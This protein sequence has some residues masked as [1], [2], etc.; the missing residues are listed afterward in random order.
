M[1]AKQVVDHAFWPEVYQA[2]LSEEFGF[3]IVA[4]GLP[5]Q[6]L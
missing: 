1:F 5:P 2:L 4:H 3:G 6:L